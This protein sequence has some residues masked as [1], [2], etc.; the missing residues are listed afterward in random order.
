M[1]F[2]GPPAMRRARPAPFEIG[3]R[4]QRR[5]QHRVAL[6]GA[7]HPEPR[8]VRETGFSLLLKMAMQFIGSRRSR[9][10]R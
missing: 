3:R 8:H 5:A 10:S 1:A 4:P 6:T 7:C 9:G 2:V